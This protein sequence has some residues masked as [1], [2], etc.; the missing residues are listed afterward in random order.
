[1][2]FYPVLRW[3]SELSEVYAFCF[4]LLLSSKPLPSIDS[5]NEGERSPNITLY[6]I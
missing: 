3:Q 5:A 4:V 6:E 1:M 2:M